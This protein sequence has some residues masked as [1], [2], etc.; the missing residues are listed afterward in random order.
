MEGI[1]QAK[2]KGVYRGRKPSIDPIE[3]RRLRIEENLGATAIAQRLGIGRA[4][5]Y[6]M[7]SAADG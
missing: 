6:R 3:V 7:L 4:S 1:A 5:V 2:T